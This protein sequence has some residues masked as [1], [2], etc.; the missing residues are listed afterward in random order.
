MKKFLECWALKPGQLTIANNWAMLPPHIE[1][2]YTRIRN[3]CTG[4]GSPKTGPKRLLLWHSRGWKV[5]EEW[6]ASFPLHKERFEQEAL[7]TLKALLMVWGKY[8]SWNS[9]W[10]ETQSPVSEYIS[11]S[12]E[13]AQLPTSCCMVKVEWIKSSHSFV[14]YLSSWMKAFFW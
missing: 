8:R 12:S 4:A 5:G 9:A 3:Q 13:W 7:M 2:V 11:V 6:L 1:D 14:S 10:L